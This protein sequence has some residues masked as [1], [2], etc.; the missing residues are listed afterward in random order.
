MI[1]QSAL[2]TALLNVESRGF[3]PALL[4]EVDALPLKV[5]LTPLR[6][7]HQQRG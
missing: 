4:E 2:R 5:P 1:S 3:D 7:A 6:T